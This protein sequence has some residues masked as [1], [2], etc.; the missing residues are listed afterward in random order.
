[1]DRNIRRQVIKAMPDRLID[2]QEAVERVVA[3]KCGDGFVA[4]WT[5]ETLRG[6]WEA[7]AIGGVRT[8]GWEDGRALIKRWLQLGELKIFGIPRWNPR[9]KCEPFELP[10]DFWRSCDKDDVAV[11]SLILSRVA[12]GDYPDWTYVLDE[13][14]LIT[15]LEIGVAT[16]E[17]EH[18][19]CV[20]AAA[21]D[22]GNAVINDDTVITEMAEW[23]FAQHPRA[24]GM[25]PKTSKQL[26]E[27]AEKRSWS[28]AFKVA[29]FITA[30]RQVYRSKPHRPPK[31]GWPLLEPYQSRL[32]S[33]G[34]PGKEK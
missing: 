34:T 31:S 16:D 1:M 5:P 13:T 25:P 17:S 24:R 20:A 11:Q 23:I 14:V 27:E 29:Y 26:Q 28:A 33:E 9:E 21:P 22:R 18:A 7:L 15:L 6:E 4:E 2:L 19:T 30:Y 8:L 32:D 12:D 10:P 3:E